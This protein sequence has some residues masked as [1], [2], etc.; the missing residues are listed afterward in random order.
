MKEGDWLI[1]YS[2]KDSMDSTKR[3]KRFTA[4]VR[5]VDGKPFT[6]YLHVQ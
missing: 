5:I 6:V 4:I 3:L 1:Y 2:P